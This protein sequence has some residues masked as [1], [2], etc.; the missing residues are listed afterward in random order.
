MNAESFRGEKND[1]F[2]KRHK[3]VF[4]NNDKYYLGRSMAGLKVDTIAQCLE[5]A[6]G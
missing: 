4:F 5:Q 3:L 2:K 6:P 1:F